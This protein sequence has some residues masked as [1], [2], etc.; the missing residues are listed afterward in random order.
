MFRHARRAMDHWYHGGGT[1]ATCVGTACSFRIC[2]KRRRHD[3][4]SYYGALTCCQYNPRI[5]IFFRYAMEHYHP[6]ETWYNLHTKRTSVG[7]RTIRLPIIQ[8]LFYRTILPPPCKLLFFWWQ[9]PP[10]PWTPS[11]RAPHFVVCSVCF[12]PKALALPQVC[13]QP[14]ADFVHIN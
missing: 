14:I 7:W 1:P 9:I 3:V 10:V 4:R 11:P 12:L 13:V 2:V 5:L 6:G 8:L